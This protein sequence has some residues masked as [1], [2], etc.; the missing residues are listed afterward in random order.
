M[1]NDDKIMNCLQQ[2]NEMFNDINTIMNKY[3]L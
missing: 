3:S 2:Y 1:Y